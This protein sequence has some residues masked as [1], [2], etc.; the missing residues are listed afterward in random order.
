MVRYFVFANKGGWDTKIMFWM[1]ILPE[2]GTPFSG[3][4]ILILDAYGEG[5]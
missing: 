4:N 5:A 3:D 1:S 2:V